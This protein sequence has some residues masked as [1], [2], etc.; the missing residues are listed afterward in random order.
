MVSLFKPDEKTFANS[1]LWKNLLLQT[2]SAVLWEGGR[3]GLRYGAGTGPQQRT[4]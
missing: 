1:L 4:V 3:G 2:R